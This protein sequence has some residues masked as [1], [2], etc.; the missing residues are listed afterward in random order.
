MSVLEKEEKRP[1]VRLGGARCEVRGARF[2]GWVNVMCEGR[3]AALDLERPLSQR[4]G[5]LSGKS[6]HNHPL[7]VQSF[8][9]ERRD[10]HNVALFPV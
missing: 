4:R 9:E 7:N 3:T 6:P 1:G 10:A 8:S 2:H 5:S